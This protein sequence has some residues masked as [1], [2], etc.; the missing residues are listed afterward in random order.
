MQGLHHRLADDTRQQYFFRPTAGKM[1][2]GSPFPCRRR[3]LTLSLIFYW[4][5]WKYFK[6]RDGI[7]Y[8]HFRRRDRS[9]ARGSLSMSYS[10]CRPLQTASHVPFERT[11]AAEDSGNSTPKREWLET[12]NV[13]NGFSYFICQSIKRHT[14]PPYLSGA[15]TGHAAKKDHDVITLDSKRPTWAIRVAFILRRNI[16]WRSGDAIFPVHGFLEISLGRA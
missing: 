6:H 10:S 9:L 5:S 12:G 11:L 14:F 1:P 8:F 16:G 7:Y 2:A 15:M 13:I 4:A 3:E